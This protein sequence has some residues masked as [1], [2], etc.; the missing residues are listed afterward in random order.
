M[1]L[2]EWKV[3]SM[4]S[5]SHDVRAPFRVAAFSSSVE[6]GRCFGLAL[7]FVYLSAGLERSVIET[8]K[9]QIRRGMLEQHLSGEN[10]RDQR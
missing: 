10:E 8:G 9:G 6:S 3:V 5:A 4:S 1:R 2:Y 7:T